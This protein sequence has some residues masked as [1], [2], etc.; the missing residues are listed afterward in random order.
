M[1][2]LN[3]VIM[4]QNCE[5]YL[6]MSL[7]SVKE[8]DNIIYCDGGSTDNTLELVSNFR[9]KEPIRKYIEGEGTTLYYAPKIIENEFKQDDKLMNSKQKNFFLD[10]LKANH[11]GEWVLYLDADEVI[12]NL[13]K[14]KEFINRPIEEIKEMVSIK[15]RHFENTLGTEDATKEEHYVPNRLFK[16]NKD[17]YFPDGEHTVL[18]GDF[19][20]KGRCNITTIF[21]LAY[22]PGIFDIRKRYLNH[23]KKSEMH[24]KEFLE[25]WY[26]SHLFGI[27][28]SKPI[29]IGDIPSIILKEFLIEPDKIYFMNRSNLEVKHFILSKQWV[30]YFKP[31]KVLELGCGLGMYGFA[32]DMMGIK[33]TGMELSQWAI[34][35]TPFKHL[36]IKQG[37]IREKQDFKDFDLVL[38]VDILE[39]LEERD[40]DKTLELIKGYGKHFLFSI[41]FLGDPNLELDPTHK[42]K[43]SKE[44]WINKLTNNFKLSPTPDNF[45]VKQQIFVGVPK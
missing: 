14:V 20:T 9:L 13:S 28:K 43:K 17:M 18:M 2:K 22:C 24:S 21:H 6:K 32:I 1:N 8:A 11:M 27:Y 39:H 19:K 41:P 12:D 31:K 29:D 26:S 34:D 37:D 36:N 30:D 15:M 40:L 4:G 44:W 45:M 23:L 3:V 38:V 33:Y 5:R 10:Y 16:V 35:N 25:D 42:I 7:E